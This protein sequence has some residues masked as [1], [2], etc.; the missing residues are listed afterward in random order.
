[1][2]YI[3]PGGGAAVGGSLRASLSDSR[4]TSHSQMPIANKLSC[5]NVLYGTIL[6]L[7]DIPSQIKRLSGTKFSV[8]T[9]RLLSYTRKTRQS[10]NYTDSPFDLRIRPLQQAPFADFAAEDLV[11]RGHGRAGGGFEET[12]E[13]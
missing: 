3:A 8:L 7:T 2:V 1:M 4:R 12:G 13:T 6:H 11:E 9:S 10:Y 5:K